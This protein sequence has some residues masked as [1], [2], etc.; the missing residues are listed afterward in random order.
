MLEKL[1]KSP[2]L[3]RAFL[4]Q[5]FPADIFEWHA[6]Q[7]SIFSIRIR[8]ADNGVAVRFAN[9]INPRDGELAFKGAITATGQGGDAYKCQK[10]EE[11][12]FHVC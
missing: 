10:N 7:S 8:K 9:R 5:A 1:K 2:V 12:L 6:K 4:L 3:C 11:G